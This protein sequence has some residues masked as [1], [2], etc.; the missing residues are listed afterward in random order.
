MNEERDRDRELEQ[1]EQTKE[2]LWALQSLPLKVWRTLSLK[3]RAA[4]EKLKESWEA[5]DERLSL[6]TIADQV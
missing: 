1:V 3:E 4:Y 6:S 5:N 2:E